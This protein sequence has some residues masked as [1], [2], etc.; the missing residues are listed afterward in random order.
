MMNDDNSCSRRSCLHLSLHS[1]K[2]DFI[3]V[4]DLL[5]FVCPFH[6]AAP[7]PVKHKGELHMYTVCV[8]QNFSSLSVNKLEKEQPVAITPVC[9]IFCPFAAGA[10]IATAI[11]VPLAVII[12]LIICVAGGYYY[13]RKHKR[14]K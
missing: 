14:P 8:L 12:L 10:I 11:V 9:L 3:L 2:V 1:I 13:Y 5:I 6:F 7:A 4:A